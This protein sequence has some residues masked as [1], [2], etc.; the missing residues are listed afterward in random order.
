[1][2]APLRHRLP[3]SQPAEPAPAARAYGDTAPEFLLEAADCIDARA[4]ARDLASGERSMA[5]AVDMFNAWRRP[6]TGTGDL[7]EADGW[8]FMALLKL[9]RA[10][11]GDY[12]RDDYVDGAAYIALAGECAQR[13]AEFPF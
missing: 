9:A 2:N 11:G 4:A 13:D 3:A 5:C 6:H 7:S 8:V 10:R 1:M 12:R